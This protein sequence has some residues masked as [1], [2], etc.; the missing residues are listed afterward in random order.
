MADDF[1][2]AAMRRQMAE[3]DKNMAAQQ[4]MYYEAKENQDEQSA[5]EAMR[6]M[7]A[8][9]TTKDNFLRHAN[10]ALNPPQQTAPYVSRETRAARGPSE[11]DTQDMADIMNE[12]RYS[13]LGTGR[14]FTAD[15]Y[16]QL[17][18]GLPWYYTNVDKK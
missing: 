16:N 9:Q 18:Q 2:L 17:R 15:H 13:K 10:Q 11:M 7:S 12:S 1:D 5:A 6:H 14:G 8:I 3:F 4:T